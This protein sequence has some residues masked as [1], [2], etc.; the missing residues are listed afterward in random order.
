MPVRFEDL[1]Q[2]QSQRLND[3]IDDINTTFEHHPVLIGAVGRPIIYA[4]P[5]DVASN[6]IMARELT[7]GFSTPNEHVKASIV[8]ANNIPYLEIRRFV[9]M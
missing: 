6:P 9:G 3:I 8:Y 1:D 5:K 4:I 7:E 2:A